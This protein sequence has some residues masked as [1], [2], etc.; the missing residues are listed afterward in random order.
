MPQSPGALP[1]TSSA[2]G[3][4]G[5]GRGLRDPIGVCG[6][7]IPWNMPVI[8]M[9]WKVGPALLAGNAL[10]LKPSSTTPLT[11]LAITGILSQSGYGV[12]N[13]VTER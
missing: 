11:S 7:I 10:V 8:L 3:H 6:A 13:I 12:L 9:G 1:G 2:S 4:P 5:T